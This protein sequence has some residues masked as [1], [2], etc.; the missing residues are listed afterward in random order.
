MKKVL[1][2]YFSN[3]A[4]KHS[5]EQN[6]LLR[7]VWKQRY[8]LMLA[9]PGLI[10][11]IL[12]CYSPMFGIVAAF[13]DYNVGLGLLKSNWVGFKWFEE[14]FTDPKFWR[15]LRNTLFFGVLN[16]LF[17]FPAPI[18]FALMINELRKSRLFKKVVQT[19]SYLPHFISWVFVA[20]FL[21]VFFSDTGT[22]NTLLMKLGLLDKPY[23]FMS[24]Q[25]SFVI[26]MVLVNIWKTFG[27][28]S[29]IYLAAMTSIPQD[30]Y[31][32]A[33]LDGAGRWQQIW[34]IT[35]PA[36]K[37]TMVVLL[38]MTVGN[39]INSNFDQYYLLQNAYVED[40]ANVLDVYTYKLGFELGRYGYATAVG[41]FKSIVSVILVVFTNRASKR[42]TGEGIY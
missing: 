22:I 27:Y 7:R 37:P 24:N 32:A 38:I 39:I 1:P 18:V 6:P 17:S 29:V 41:L 40:I 16:L 15:S 34:H 30:M 10:W 25:V 28:N 35:L 2:A 36:I 11:M 13:K 23:G 4:K 21:T 31:E 42:L 33:E 20:S 5:L 3:T 19:I 8:L 9:I 14:L 26:I 12:F